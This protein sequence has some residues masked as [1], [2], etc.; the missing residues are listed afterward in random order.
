MINTNLRSLPFNGGIGATPR[1]KPEFM[2]EQ[3]LDALG[4]MAEEAQ[5]KRQIDGGAGGGQDGEPQAPQPLTPMGINARYGDSAQR[6]GAPK[7][8]FG[9]TAGSPYF[10]KPQR[11]N[12]IMGYAKG[13]LF[14]RGQ[15]MLVGEEGPELVVAKTDGKVIPHDKTRKFFQRGK[16]KC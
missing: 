12:A 6:G 1:L 13:G 10:Y 5:L 15:A 3:Y 9:A 8:G 2:R 16:K 14:K 4:D 11:G 7:L